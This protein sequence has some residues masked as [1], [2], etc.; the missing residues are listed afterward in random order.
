LNVYNTT[1]IT[2]DGRT[3]PDWNE[4][5]EIYI[6]EEKHRRI[7]VHIDIS[8][9]T[10][11]ALC[12]E[13]DK[14][15]FTKGYCQLA[16]ILCRFITHAATEPE[17]KPLG[18]FDIFFTELLNGEYHAENGVI[19]KPLP[20]IEMGLNIPW[21]LTA[22]RSI[23]LRSF[24]F[25]QKRLLSEIKTLPFSKRA[26]IFKGD[27]IIA[28]C[29]NDIE[30]M[31]RRIKRPVE[32]QSYSIGISMAF[33]AM[34]DVYSRYH[35]CMA[36]ISAGGK[37]VNY[38][39]EIAFSYLLGETGKANAKPLFRHPALEI[40]RQKGESAAELYE[41]LR[42]YLFHERGG[43]ETAKALAIHRNTLSYRLL[44][45]EELTNI[46]LDNTDERHF[47]LLSFLLEK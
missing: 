11:L 27:I 30:Q 25:R 4:I 19:L 2:A 22:V 10:M 33:S 42:Q 16:E 41:T 23:S 15:I 28:V 3:L 35:Q 47:A 38:A 32:Q 13:E 17:Y 24:L 21:V 37:P 46:D 8:D 40:L 20:R 43:K 14:K 5:P 18:S 45:I 9:G 44:Q 29:Q 36:A 12:I 39:A 7:G 31:L 34:E 1:V 26:V 6:K